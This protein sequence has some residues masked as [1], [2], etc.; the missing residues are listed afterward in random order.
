M[1]SKGDEGSSE[2]NFREQYIDNNHKKDRT[3]TDRNE[4]TY[5]KP[6]ISYAELIVEAI[7]YAPEGMLTLKEIYSAIN[8]RYP[9]YSMKKNG[10][11]NSI[12]HNLSLNKAFYKVPRA[13]NNPG[14]GAYWKLSQDHLNIKHNY[15]TRR[16]NTRYSN[17]SR[18]MTDEF[19]SIS[20]I[21][22]A[23]QT[24]LDNIGVTEMPPKENVTS[25][26]DGNLNSLYD[27]YEHQYSIESGDGEIKNVCNVFSFKK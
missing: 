22:T 18:I 20:E 9:Y 13:L 2:S 23:N 17:R 8:K 10:W 24:F 15:R 5:K 26:F 12:R 14:K 11:Q 6:N 4:M 21:L 19:S 25:I 3:H 1:F 16:T 27:S 7:S